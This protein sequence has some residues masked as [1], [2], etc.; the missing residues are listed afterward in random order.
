[1][2][3]IEVYDTESNGFVPS[4]LDCRHNKKQGRPCL[5]RFLRKG[6]C[7][8]VMTGLAIHYLGFPYSMRSLPCYSALLTD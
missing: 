1:M 4:R 3:L 5:A 8:F 6:L 2:D 7:A